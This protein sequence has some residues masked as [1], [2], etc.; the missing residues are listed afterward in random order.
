MTKDEIQWVTE[1]MSA[2]GVKVVAVVQHK[3]N[4]VSFRV[5][6]IRLRSS[7]T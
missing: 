1:K 3:D 2:M 6:R 7:K 5:K 4:S